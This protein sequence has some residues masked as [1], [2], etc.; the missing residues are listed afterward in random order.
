[1]TDFNITK[2]FKRMEMKGWNCIYFAIDVHDT[3]YESNYSNVDHQRKWFR[4]A[5][6]A[7]QILTKRKDCKLI[8]NTC[9]HPKFIQM[10]VD[11]FEE[12]DIHFD[13]INSNPGVP[14]NDLSDFS[15]K[16]YFDVFLDDKAGFHGPTDWSLVLQS[17]NTNHEKL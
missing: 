7:L 14:S 3:I 2:A 13:Y 17:L 6:E 16:F 8:L 15:S 10:M 5:K 9:T 11:F 12:N 1:M 4:G